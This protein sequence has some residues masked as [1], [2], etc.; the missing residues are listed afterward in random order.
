MKY[1]FESFLR[2]ASSS[3][4]IASLFAATG[5]LV[6]FALPKTASAAEEI[7]LNVGGPILVSVSI[8]S[9]ETFA[10]SGEIG[11]DLRLITR[12]LNENELQRIRQALQRPVALSVVQ[13]DNLVY[14]KLGGDFLQNLGKVFK[15][16]RDINGG[17]ALRGAL[18][19]AAAQ[20]GPEGWTAID[21]LRQF[22]TH[23]IDIEIGDLLTL[24]RSLSVY[25]G[26]NEAVV[27]AIQR[28]SAAEAA[29]QSA[30]NP[31][32]DFSQL[33]PYQY[34][35]GS[36]T[37]SP[38]AIRQTRDGLQVNYD[39]SVETYVPQG[40]TQPAPVILISHGFGDVQESFDFIAS[41]LASYGYVVMLPD[42]VGSDLS[43]RQSFLRGSV[44]TIL[45]PSE[46]VSRPQEVSLV[47]NE[48][49][50]LAETSTDW[51]ATLDLDRI[52][53]VGDSLGGSTV[54]ALAGADIDYDRIS[55]LCTDEQVILNLSMYLQCQA[56]F[57]PP[58]NLR[59]VDDRI[60]AVIASHP[61]GGGLYGP[62]GMG[63]I[64]IPTMTFS[65]S[66]DIVAT[67]V[68]EQV[69]PFIWTGSQDKYLAL[70]TRGTHFT[71]KPGREGVEGFITALVGE[72]RDIGSRYFKELNIVFWNTYL[73]E[74][75]EFLP[76]LSARYGK[77]ISEGE[78]LLLDI[79]GSLSPEAL[80][81]AYGQA[82]PTAIIPEPSDSVL[83]RPREESV[84]AEI[85]RTGVLKVALR[86][87]ASPFGYID[88]DDNWVGYCHR[89]AT[90]LQ[91][92]VDQTVGSQVEVELVRISSTLDSRFSLVQDETAH[93]ECGPNTIRED[94]EGVNFS[95][96][97]AVSGTQFLVPRGTID[98]E[99][100]NPRLDGLRVAV[101][102][103]TTTAQFVEE[104]FPQANV[105][106]FPGP[107]GRSE[108]ISA[109]G[110][111]EVDV[112][113]SDGILSISEL[114]RQNLSLADYAVVPERPLTCEFYG[115]ALPNNDQEWQTMINNFLRDTH[116]ERLEQEVPTP[117]LAGQIETLDYCLNR[118]PD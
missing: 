95:S 68:T 104:T 75:T 85:E 64:N 32:Q 41:H 100:A 3:F 33:G 24:R 118:A 69:H 99:D 87:D 72:N 42:H 46:F 34:E 106:S 80:T 18:L 31:S 96:P 114:L 7:R 37:L 22:P 47:I 28:Q 16:H 94:I 117:L 36:F 26:Y 50:R 52:G 105:V 82:P 101:L 63:Q 27:E 49:E 51:A 55:A 56:R 84:L 81:T 1:S 107:I 48:L 9:L 67:M 25:L 98:S 17:Q 53:M 2:I 21:V 71:V 57:L 65:G 20:A 110:M 83:R 70:L 108:A 44:D 62:E 13:T 66:N 79:I 45:S 29:Q 115:L 12:F 77:Q 73:K 10:E 91:A 59:L 30:L 92:H 116:I 113:A 112:V 78:P 38:S 35:R 93:V 23:S 5:T 14:S 89:F 111:G 61:L 39:F 86:K 40:L 43:V 58:Q 103:N 76:Y 4:A 60:K 8:D 102:S 19:T 109:L 15:V 97:L 74:Q 6:D 54:L 11:S 90:D 88:S